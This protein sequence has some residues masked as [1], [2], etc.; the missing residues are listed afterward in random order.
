MVMQ[1]SRRFYWA[2]RY[3]CAQK[4]EAAKW[5]QENF[6]SHIYKT[7]SFGLITQIFIQTIISS[8]QQC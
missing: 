3:L 5:Q 7:I 2:T 6:K 4:T 1:S 8:Q